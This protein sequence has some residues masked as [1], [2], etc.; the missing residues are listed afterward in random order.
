MTNAKFAR[1]TQTEFD[2]RIAVKTGWG[3]NEISHVLRESISEI[4]LR[5][6]E[7]RE[8]V[9]LTPERNERWKTVLESYDKT[10]GD[11]NDE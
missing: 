1:L 10:I 3:K 8:T 4:A 9:T 7:T 6:F 5:L 2:T 11:L